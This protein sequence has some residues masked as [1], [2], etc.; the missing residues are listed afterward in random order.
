M[1]KFRA[2]SIGVLMTEPKLRSEAL[3]VGAKTFV[4]TMAK[5]FVYGYDESISSKYLEKGIAVED[6]SIALYNEVF[7]TNHRKNMERRSNEWVQGEADIVGMDRIIDTKS[8]W[9]LSTFPATSE[10]A[11][12]KGYEWQVRTYMMLWD[13]PFAEVA[14]CLV[15]TPDHLIGYE[16]PDLHCVD[17]INPALRVTRVLYE[18]DAALEER[19]KEKVGYARAYFD[20]MVKKI[21]D[22]HGA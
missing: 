5:Q 11:T 3:S 6:E 7:F 14:H 8:S 10:A 18:R 21:A 17:H 1:H 15:N 16:N 22:Q 4:E 13:K 2:H 9:S 12:D 20:L 19:I